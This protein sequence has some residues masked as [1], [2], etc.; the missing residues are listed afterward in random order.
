MLRSNQNFVDIGDIHMFTACMKE[1]VLC[2]F[3]CVGKFHFPAVNVD[4][5]ENVSG[6]PFFTP[7]PRNARPDLAEKNARVLCFFHSQETFQ[8]DTYPVNNLWLQYLGYCDIKITCVH[9]SVCSNYNPQLIG[10]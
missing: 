2:E 3:L 6:T 8:M 10:L 7:F 1:W 9:V 4:L 5:T